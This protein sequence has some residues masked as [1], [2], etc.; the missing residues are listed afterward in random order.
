M[1]RPI[2]LGDY[3]E[4]ILSVNN[5]ND[6]PKRYIIRTTDNLD[7]YVSN[8]SD[9][10][11]S[12]E[13]LVLSPNEY[14]EY[15]VQNLNVEHEIV[16]INGDLLTLP[17]PPSLSNYGSINKIMSGNSDVDIL[18]LSKAYPLIGGIYRV[19]FD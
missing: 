3:V 14:G 13:T 7:I 1:S 4:I 12:N 6:I 5:A 17:S 10:S 18:I 16:F 9:D 15:Q 8:V 11:M 19:Y 2:T